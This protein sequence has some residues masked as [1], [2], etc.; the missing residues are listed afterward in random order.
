MDRDEDCVLLII[1]GD[2]EQRRHKFLCVTVATVVALATLGGVWYL[3]LFIF[4]VYAGSG[5]GQSV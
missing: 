5:S 2:S 4:L 1:L 3:F